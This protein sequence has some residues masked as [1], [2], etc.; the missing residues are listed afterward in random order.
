[1]PAL[2][3]L[4]ICTIISIKNVTSLTDVGDIEYWKLREILRRVHSPQ[5]LHQIELA[6]PQ[7]CGEDAEL[8][9]AFIVRD[10]PDWKRKN[11]VPKNPRK[12]YEV[13]MKYMREQTQEIERDRQQLRETMMGLQREKDNHRSQL[14]KSVNLP[15]LMKDRRMLANN[16]GVPIG[17]RRDSAGPARAKLTDGQSFLMRARRE[18]KE[19]SARNKS[20]APSHQAGSAASRVNKAPQ[21]MLDEYRRAAASRIRIFTPQKN[22]SGISNQHGSI[23]QPSLEERER[24]L[25]ALTMSGQKRD[26]S[27]VV[28]PNYVGSDDDEEDELDD[29]FGE[30]TPVKAPSPLKESTPRSMAS[31]RPAPIIRREKVSELPSAPSSSTPSIT[32]SSNQLKS[33]KTSE[34]VSA[35]IAK[36]ASRDSGHVSTKVQPRST[37]S[38][39]PPPTTGR[40][41]SPSNGDSRT[42][43]RPLMAPRKKPEVDI[44][45]R[46]G[47]A[48]KRQRLR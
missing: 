12:W 4:A 30:N 40:G 24:R 22:L 44:F 39:S 25:R 9:K 21:A 16:G 2:S 46:E 43:P 41:L 48:A 26:S 27:G 11:Y 3:L 42:S 23:D 32:K 47:K 1:M 36:S 29:L 28:K 6:S 31:S 33:S 8:W 20:S 38:I 19:L 17:R 15:K 18:T 10:I 35:G 45:N 5:Q 13:Y 14:M 7:I 37:S 34:L